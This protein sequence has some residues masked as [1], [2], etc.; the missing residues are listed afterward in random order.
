VASQLIREAHFLTLLPILVL[1]NAVPSNLYPKWKL[2][3]VGTCQMSDT[4]SERDSLTSFECEIKA[5]NSL[6]FRS[7]SPVSKSSVFLCYQKQRYSLI[8]RFGA[9][10]SGRRPPLTETSLNS[11]SHY[12]W[13]NLRALALHCVLAYVFFMHIVATYSSGLIT[14]TQS[15]QSHRSPSVSQ[16]I[17]QKQNLF[18][19]ICFEVSSF[20]STRIRE[21]V[22]R[23]LPVVGASSR[24]SSYPGSQVS[25]SLRR[26]CVQ[27]WISCSE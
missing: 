9:S 19:T 26:L 6:S 3:G 1:L 20:Q 4:H 17:E 22:G 13:A 15:P 12:L 8:V 27:M 5:G 10:Y 18:C 21:L 2:F 7:D 14:R 16:Q 24:P 23:L 25:Y 11:E